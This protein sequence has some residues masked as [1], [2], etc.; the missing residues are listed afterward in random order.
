[1]EKTSFA[2]N[3][4]DRSHR[5]VNGATPT[6]LVLERR[7]NSAAHAGRTNAATASVTTTM[8]EKPASFAA[9]ADD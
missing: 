2:A 5:S 1:M 3:A 8:T 4:D 6:P 9:N 7:T